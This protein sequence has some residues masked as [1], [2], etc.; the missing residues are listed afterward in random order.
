MGDG[1]ARVMRSE[2]DPWQKL[3]L[4]VVCSDGQKFR[5]SLPLRLWLV[6]SAGSG[7]SRTVRAFAGAKRDEVRKKYQVK[8][9]AA[10]ALGA[11][12]QVKQLTEAERVG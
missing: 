8:K 7:K 12:N 2:L 3:A 4:D 9:D 10:R 5:G 11:N 1:A 6:G